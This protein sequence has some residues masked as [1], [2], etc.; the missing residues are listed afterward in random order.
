MDT[1]HPSILQTSSSSCWWPEMLLQSVIR[2]PLVLG[3]LSFFFPASL[4][5]FSVPIT[6]CHNPHSLII[7]LHI[8]WANRPTSCFFRNVLAILG[9]LF[10][11]INL[12]IGLF[13]SF[14]NPVGIL[15]GIVLSLWLNLGIFET[16]DISNLLAMNWNLPPF[17]YDLFNDFSLRVYTFLYKSL[18]HLKNNYL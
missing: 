4:V 11:H 2:L 6:H 15:I 1:S 18:P 5:S 13:S 14:K 7:N 12:R 3:F 10:F 9:S 17:I 8:F 16:W